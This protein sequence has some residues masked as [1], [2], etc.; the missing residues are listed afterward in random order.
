VA[1]CRP[2]L[3][4]EI[5]KRSRQARGFV[6]LPM[7][8]VVERTLAWRNRCRRLVKAFDNHTDNALAL[9][10]LASIRKG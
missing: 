1:K 10:Q 2:H 6:V 3:A 9:L 4:T 8:W 7:R 5:I